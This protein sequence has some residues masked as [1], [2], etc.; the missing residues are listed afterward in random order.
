MLLVLIN[1]EWMLQVLAYD[2]L[3]MHEIHHIINAMICL[4]AFVIELELH[5]K[6]EIEV[7]IGLVFVRLIRLL[8]Q[9]Y[10]VTAKVNE[11]E[12]E[13][14]EHRYQRVKDQIEK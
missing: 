10:E 2:V 14:M 4:T 7:L 11:H 13:E 6:K 9:L 3:F 5:G 8:F 1:L 12:Y